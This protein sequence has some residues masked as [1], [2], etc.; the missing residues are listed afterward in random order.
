MEEA[1]RARL[2][3]SLSLSLAWGV[4]GLT[5]SRPGGVKKKRLTWFPVWLYVIPCMGVCSGILVILIGTNI[6]ASKV[7]GSCFAC[8]PSSYFRNWLYTTLWY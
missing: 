3:L 5:R 8:I 7:L 1:R 4:P 6:L 2:P